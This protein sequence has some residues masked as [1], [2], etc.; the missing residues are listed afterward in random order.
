MND[1]FLK[2][3]RKQPRPEFAEALY[4]QLRQQADAHPP[5]APFSS[6]SRDEEKKQEDKNMN[7]QLY[8]PTLTLPK[9]Y[10]RDGRL[11]ALAAAVAV[12]F[13]STLL[14]FN[15]LYNYNMPSAPF[16][17]NLYSGLSQPRAVS[18]TTLFEQYINEVWNAGNLEML[19]ELLA[20]D[21]VCYEPGMTEGVVGVEHMMAMITS[22]RTAFPDWQFTI[23]DLVTVDATGSSV[24][25]E[26]MVSARIAY[27][28]IAEQRLQYDALGLLSQLGA[29]SSP[30]TYL[31]EQRNMEI[32]RQGLDAFNQHDIDAMLANFAPTFRNSWGV[33]RFETLHYPASQARFSLIFEQQL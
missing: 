7:A 28:K 3:F 32:M 9:T 1:E 33:D 5:P 16:N 29:V 4:E 15:G 19:D 2:Q 11:V 6:D 21:H 23:E 8:L 14:V 26:V 24:N 12:I 18:S 27:G 10:P 30:D 25:L 13:I 31:M 20:A 17:D 22:Y